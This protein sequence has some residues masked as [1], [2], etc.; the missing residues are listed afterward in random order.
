MTQG[1]SSLLATGMVVFRRLDRRRCA[2]LLSM[3]SVGVF[4]H[5]KIA[6]HGSLLSRKALLNRFFAIL[7]ADSAL[8]FAFGCLGEE[9][10]WSNSHS[11]AKRLNCAVN[12]GPFVRDYLV[13][14]TLP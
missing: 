14:L 10:T 12:C 13:R 9:V 3:F 6:F 7:T 1:S 5:C 2:G 8:P 11:E 4:L